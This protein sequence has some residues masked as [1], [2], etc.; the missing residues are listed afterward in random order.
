MK[1]NKYNLIDHFIFGT[2]RYT[3][4]KIYIKRHNKYCMINCLI[5]ISIIILIWI[6]TFILFGSL[7]SLLYICTV[8]FFFILC[9]VKLYSWMPV[10]TIKISLL[11]FS[12]ILIFLT[13]ISEVSLEYLNIF[14]L[15]I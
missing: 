12:P 4:I 5:I 6:S 13:N 11:W 3:G 9:I 1:N 14:C 10:L 7:M 2:Y 8:M 15:L